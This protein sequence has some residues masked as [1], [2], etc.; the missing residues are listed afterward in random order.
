MA[1]TVLMS[2]FGLIA[3]FEGVF[4]LLHLHKPFLVFDPN[5]NQYLP[6]QFLN[7]GIVMTIVGVLCIIAAWT[8][9]I[10]FLVIMIIIGCVTETLMAF[11][12]TADFRTN[13]H[14]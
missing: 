5:K 3:L 4:L 9:S 1:I 8:D 6:K 10:G 12:I 14:R 2:L 11:A 7:W 13:K